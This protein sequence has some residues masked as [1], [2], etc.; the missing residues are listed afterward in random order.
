MPHAPPE[1]SLPTTFALADF[2]P[3]TTVPA[4]PERLTSL[5]RILVPGA[6]TLNTPSQLPMRS[7]PAMV[8]LVL[9]KMTSIAFSPSGMLLTTLFTT[10]VLREPSVT[11]IPP[12]LVLGLA[13][14][15]FLA[16]VVLM[17]LTPT[18][19]PP[20]TLPM[21]RF[22]TIVASRAPL[23]SIANNPPSLS[24]KPR[25]VKPETLTSFTR[26][27]SVKVSKFTSPTTQ[28]PSG[29]KALEQGESALALVGASITASSPRSLMP[30]LLITTSSRW[31]PLTT[32]VSPGSA[33]FTAFWIDS[34]GP[35]TELSALAVPTPA[36]SASPLA[37]SRVRAIVANNSMV[38]LISRPAFHVRGTG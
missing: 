26:S 32:I 35:T 34:P 13:I 1:M 33:A 17:L 36:A 23:T 16:I 18:M 37:T 2:W 22:P 29:P 6:S 8:V 9:S 4:K 19:I 5:E 30:S 38:R 24:S 27:L 25:N 14:T 21:T 28:I 10:L 20:A 11:T 31:T 7:F 15:S 3:A 12:A